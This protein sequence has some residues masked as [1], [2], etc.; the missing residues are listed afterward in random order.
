MGSSGMYM[1][2]LVRLVLED[3]IE[4]ELIFTNQDTSVLKEKGSFPTR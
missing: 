1:G 2:E 4:E 3:M